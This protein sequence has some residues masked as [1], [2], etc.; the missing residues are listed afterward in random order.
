[1]RVQAYGAH[2]FVWVYLYVFEKLIPKPGGK[3]QKE[4]AR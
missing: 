2:V 3:E 1:M 4:P